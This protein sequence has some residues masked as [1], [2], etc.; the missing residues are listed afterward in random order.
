ALG[1]HM[2]INTGTIMESE[3]P[4]QLKGVMAHETGHIALGHNVTRYDAMGAA[5]GTS[6][7]TLG[8]GALALAAGAP[9]AAMALFGSAGQFGMLT[10][11]KF[12]RNEE[13]AADQYGLDLLQK[14]GQSGQGLIDFFEKFA[15]EEMMSEN[16]REP[17]FRSHPISR[18]RIGA[19]RKRAETVR[20]VAATDADGDKSSV[21]HCVVTELHPQDDKSIQQLAMMKAKLVGFIGPANKVLTRYPQSDQS[22]PAKYARAIAAYRAVDIKTALRGTQELIDADPFNPYFYELKGQILFESGKTE[23]SVEPHRKSVELAPNQPLLKVNLARSLTATKKKEDINEAEGLLI[24]AIA[25]E[26][27]N[28][29]SWNQLA[30]VYAAQDRVGDADL[31]TAEEAYIVGNMARAQHFA[32]RALTKLDPNTPNGQRASDIAALSDPRNFPGRKGGRQPLALDIYTK[33]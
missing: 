19:L 21:Q 1:Q 7:V 10:M 25:L 6:L 15:Y 5:Q 29:F 8:L 28:P 11:F 13:S 30:A 20:C 16:R 12:T 2:F 17:Y 23:E 4:E 32:G 3:T 27:N 18:D 9:D 26:K 22:M 31:A 14:T 33:Q 24:D